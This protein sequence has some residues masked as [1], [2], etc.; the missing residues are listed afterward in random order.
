MSWT[1]WRTPASRQFFGRLIVQPY[2]QC[3]ALAGVSPVDREMTLADN[4]CPFCG[5]APQVSIRAATSQAPDGTRYLEYATCRAHG[6][7]VRRSARTAARPTRG[8]S[9][10]ISEWHDHIR[11]DTCDSCQRYLKSIDLSVLVQRFPSS[12]R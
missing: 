1:H 3:L 6:R 7:S 9:V 12:T 5:G 4:L 10:T 8:V 2:A 11:V